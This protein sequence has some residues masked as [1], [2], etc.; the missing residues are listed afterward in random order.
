M[1]RA[2]E[3]IHLAHRPPEILQ[4]ENRDTWTGSKSRRSSSAVQNPDE[5]LHVLSLRVQDR[6]SLTQRPGVV[7]TTPGVLRVPG[8]LDFVEPHHAVLAPD[9]VNAARSF[10]RH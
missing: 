4:G 2:R 5:Q 8:R 6:R 3:I 1:S 10:R 7:A 9:Q